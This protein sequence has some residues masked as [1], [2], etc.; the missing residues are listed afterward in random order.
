MH[1]PYPPNP[2]DYPSPGL[3]LL[4]GLCAIAVIFV[5]PSFMPCNPRPCTS[6]SQSWTKQDP[7]AKAINSRVALFQEQDCRLL[8]RYFPH[9]EI[10]RYLKEQR[11]R[12]T[13][14]DVYQLANVF[15]GL[16][17]I[18]DIHQIHLELC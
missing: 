6:P 13:G 16:R 5:V 15:P 14:V 17:I 10:R 2:A 1:W 7:E 8:L 12:L 4:L 11:V 3:G 18:R 9:F